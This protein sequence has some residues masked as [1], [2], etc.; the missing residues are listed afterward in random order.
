MRAT[1]AGVRS[2]GWSWAV[3][4]VQEGEE[5]EA[6]HD[7]FGL[8]LLSCRGGAER[9]RGCSRAASG[10]TI[11]RLS[12]GRAAENALIH[13]LVCYKALATRPRAAA[14][15]ALKSRQKLQFRGRHK[16]TETVL[17]L[18]PS[19]SCGRNAYIQHSPARQSSAKSDGRPRLQL[20]LG[21]GP[22]WTASRSA[23][24]HLRRG[25]DALRRSARSPTT[26]PVDVVD[27]PAARGQNRS[28]PP[29]WP[30]A[31]P[32]PGSPGAGGEPNIVAPRL[33]D[34]GAA[35]PAAARGRPGTWPTPS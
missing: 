8:P 15:L 5:R 10:R 11:E 1:V 30:V 31:T 24:H 22:H 34:P 35:A 17:N 14:W 29:S 7:G 2:Q 25:R 27:A 3:A 6:P 12:R 33:L 23:S 4:C 20:D 19:S 13:F 21:S 28:S 16:R 32:T 18:T 9:G 26:T